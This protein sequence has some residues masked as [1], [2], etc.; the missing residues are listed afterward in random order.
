[1][2]DALAAAALEDVQESGD[3][4]LH[5]GMRVDQR[6]AYPGLSGE[7]DDDVGLLLCEDVFHGITVGHVQLDELV[8]ALAIEPRHAGMLQAHV[9]VVVDVVEAK[10]LIA[11]REQP[12]R[13]MIADESRRARHEVAHPAS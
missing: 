7:M 4:A 1:M 8:S 12:L 9:V 5:V 11:A 10:H 6:V 13:D 2:A 3:I